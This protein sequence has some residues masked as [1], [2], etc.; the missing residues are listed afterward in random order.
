[1]YLALSTSRNG[2]VLAGNPGYNYP[3]YALILPEG[4]LNI[5]TVIDWWSTVTV[6]ILQV[7]APVGKI[8][9]AHSCLVTNKLASLRLAYYGTEHQE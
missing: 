8:S 6:E 5:T 2:G 4:P 1:M 9:L 7:I 3:A